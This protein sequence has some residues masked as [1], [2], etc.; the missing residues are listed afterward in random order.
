MK[1]ILKNWPLII[2]FILAAFLRFYRL[3]QVPTS[4]HTDEAVFGYNAYS[5]LKTGRDEYGHFPIF[6]L[7]SF[8]DYRPALYLFL[9]IPSVAVFGLT[10]FA[11]RLPTAIIS[12]ATVILFYFLAVRIFNN[13][14]AGWYSVLLMG[15]SFWHLDLSRE[16]SEKVLALFLI[17]LG[18]FFFYLFLEKKKTGWLLASFFWWFL[19]IHAYY[20]PRFFL[21]FFL[22]VLFFFY[23]KKLARTEKVRFIVLSGLLLSVVV[24]FSFF[25]Q[26]S[27][28]RFQQLNIFTHPEVKLV[29]QEQIREEIPG[30][31]PLVTRFFHNKLSNYFLA[32]ISK[33]GEYFTLKFLS[34]QGGEPLRVAVPNTGLLS[35]PEIPFLL[36]GLYFLL[37][38]KKP[39]AGFVFAWIF[40]AP[41]PAAFTVDETPSVYRS[42]VMLPALNL[43]TAWGFCKIKSIVAHRSKTW[44]LLMLVVV[45][46][47]YWWNVLYYCHQY[48]VHQRFHRP[49]FRHYGYRQLNAAIK[50]LYP[51]YNEIIMTKA[52]GS[53][54]IFILFYQ[55]FDP[56]VYQSMG[57]PRDLDYRGFDKYRFSPYDCPSYVK[58]NVLQEEKIL[59]VD[60]GECKQRPYANILETVTREDHTPVFYLVEADREAA[61]AY[62]EK[63]ENMTPEELKGE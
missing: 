39:W 49:W 51:E 47:F 56:G 11:V 15:L 53:P 12:L 7:E 55:Q 32:L 63:A 17:L 13:R 24:Y 60:K 41:L 57:S 28:V 62:F 43:A 38:E 18:L 34:L 9:T 37:R 31:N 36:A 30:T 25:Y 54:Y 35:L 58:E 45:G 44:W 4:L 20:A 61:A 19:S 48:Y 5:I 22:P 8:N 14:E 50:A 1:K 3:S 16:A 10:A 27:V 42:L 52:H 21:P 6:V 46:G 26:G 29:L 23:R 33:Y 40:I 2:I 59:F